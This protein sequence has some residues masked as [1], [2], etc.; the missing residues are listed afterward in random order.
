[1]VSMS[2]AA[3]VND[4]TSQDRPSIYRNEA[5]RQAVRDWCT[6]QLDRWA[7]PHQRDYLATSAGSTHVVTAGSGSPTIVLVPGTNVNVAT[8]W[9]VERTARL[10]SPELLFGTL[11]ER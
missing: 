10:L 1:M 9:A 3:P 2:G 4:R 7:L 5:W 11:N 6:H 8:E